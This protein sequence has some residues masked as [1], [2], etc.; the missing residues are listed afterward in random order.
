MTHAIYMLDKYD[1]RHT[2]KSTSPLLLLHGNSSYANA[3][4]C[5]VYPLRS[6]CCALP[7]IDVH[8]SRFAAPLLL[9]ALHIILFA[10]RI[11]RIYDYAT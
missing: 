10:Q 2:L 5:V 3:P 4:Q 9:P 11:L 6:L 7:V 1:Y 8:L